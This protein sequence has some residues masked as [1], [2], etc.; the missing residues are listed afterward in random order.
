[1]GFRLGAHEGKAEAHPR[2]GKRKLHLGK[3]KNR[4]SSGQIGVGSVVPRKIVVR[5]VSKGKQLRI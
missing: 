2:K 3:D 1:M 5:K 4:R